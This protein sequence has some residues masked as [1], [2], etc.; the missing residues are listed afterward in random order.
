MYFEL[1]LQ[2]TLHCSMTPR[3]KQL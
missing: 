2:F 1:H 3:C